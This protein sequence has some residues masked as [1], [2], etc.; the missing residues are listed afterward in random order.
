MHIYIYVYTFRKCMLLE[1]QTDLWCS[2]VS[3]VF[4]ISAGFRML[5]DLWCGWISVGFECGWISAGLVCQQHINSSSSIF[6]LGTL[7]AGLQANRNTTHDS[8]FHSRVK[9]RWDDPRNTTP[10]KLGNWSAESFIW[11]QVHAVNL[12]PHTRY[13]SIDISYEVLLERYSQVLLITEGHA[14]IHIYIYICM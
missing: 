11:N 5:P 13:I 10:S 9:H 12:N 8:N 4:R 14:C 7:W 6:L 1:F 2:R 3:A